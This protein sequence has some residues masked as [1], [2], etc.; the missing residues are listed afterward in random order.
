MRLKVVLMV[1]KTMLRHLLL[2]TFVDYF[3]SCVQV[4]PQG[5]I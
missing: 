2:S 1:I 4:H 3:K 5:S